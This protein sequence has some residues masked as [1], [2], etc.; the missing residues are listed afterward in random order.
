M[1]KPYIIKLCFLFFLFFYFF[2]ACRTGEI[3]NGSNGYFSTPN[4]PVNYPPHSRCTW[5]I[6]VPSG[7]IIKVNF[8]QF[9]LDPYPNHDRVTITN[10]ASNDG[11]HPFQL[12]GKSHPSPVYS[13]GNSI[14]VIFA[15]LNNQ[16]SGFH[17]TYTAITF[18]SGRYCY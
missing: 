15:T 17:A 9:K 3:L 2:V 5:N 11:R 6:T 1:L 16:S 4:F 13:E 8:L 18:E 12:Y 7:H 14:Q 10:V